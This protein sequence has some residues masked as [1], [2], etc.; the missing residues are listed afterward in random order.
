[1]ADFECDACDKDIL[2]DEKAWVLFPGTPVHCSGDFFC[3]CQE[4]YNDYLTENYK[5]MVKLESC[6]SV[7]YENSAYTIFKCNA[8]NEDD[9]DRREFECKCRC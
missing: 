4:C 3:L 7:L 1:M 8:H 2:P 9:L 6:N 5:K